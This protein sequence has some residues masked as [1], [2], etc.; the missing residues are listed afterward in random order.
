MYKEQ[1]IR[2]LPVAR[3]SYGQTSKSQDFKITN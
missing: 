2:N 3:L 1:N